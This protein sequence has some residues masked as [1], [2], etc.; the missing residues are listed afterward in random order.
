[1]RKQ[2]GEGVLHKSATNLLAQILHAQGHDSEAYDILYPTRKNL[3]LDQL[4]LLHQLAY[5][6][7]HFKEAIE[8]GNTLYQDHPTDNV[9]LI[10]ALSNAQLGEARAAVGWL[11]CA[12]KN[13]LPNLKEVL[14]KEDFN[15]IRQDPLFNSLAQSYHA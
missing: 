10:N 15:P 14:Q 6:Q 12:I 1:M 2:A 13:G 4:K 11:Q 5:S 9:A 8:I 3:S 7:N